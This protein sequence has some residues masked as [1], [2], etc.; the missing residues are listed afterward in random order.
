MTESPSFNVTG[1]EHLFCWA[2]MV[3]LESSSLFLTS[4]CIF[5]KI[6]NWLLA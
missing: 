5:E 2:H 6:N 4:L 3:A 1:E